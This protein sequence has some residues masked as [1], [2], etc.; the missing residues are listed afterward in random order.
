MKI[1]FLKAKHW[2]IIALMG[3]LGLSA[4][5]KD[6]NDDSPRLMYGPPPKACNAVE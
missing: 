6:E 4:C 3:I 2:L 5:S 1:K